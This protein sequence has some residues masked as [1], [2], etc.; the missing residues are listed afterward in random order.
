MGKSF[1]HLLVCCFIANLYYCYNWPGFGNILTKQFLHVSTIITVCA[2]GP[3][4]GWL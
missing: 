2:I 3:Y 1:L 4:F